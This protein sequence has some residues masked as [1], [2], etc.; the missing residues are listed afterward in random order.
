MP[1]SDHFIVIENS[2]DLKK[3]KF[4]T[5]G[6]FLKYEELAHFTYLLGDAYILILNLRPQ[7]VYETLSQFKIIKINFKIFLKHTLS[8]NA[9]KSKKWSLDMNPCEVDGQSQS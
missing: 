2:P 6:K 4:C 5:Q 1:P 8:E 9:L 7:I 3:K